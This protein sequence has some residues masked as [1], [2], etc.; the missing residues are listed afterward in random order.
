MMRNKKNCFVDKTTGQYI[1][2][3]DCQEFKEKFSMDDVFIVGEIAVNEKE[4]LC[5]KNKKRIE[6]DDIEI[7]IKP[8][9]SYEGKKYKTIGYIPC[10]DNEYIVVKKKKRVLAII[11]LLTLLLLICGIIGGWFMLKQQNPEIDP[12]VYDYTS[13]LKRPDNIEDSKIMLPGYGKFTIDKGSNEIDTV[14]FN[15]E[16]N[17]CFFQFILVEKGTN[18]VLYES[19]LVPPGKGIS[20][21]KMTKSFDKTGSYN[22]VL[23]FKTVDLENTTITY[24]GSEME[25][26]L[27]VVDE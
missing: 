7:G 26:T 1:D 18:E 6:Q 24:N 15:P 2:Y 22:A 11:Y 25:V 5:I 10:G 4:K 20:P 21:I 14:L 8:V 17:P 16:G 13:S 9:G 19:K 12:N 27:N 23:K 3:I